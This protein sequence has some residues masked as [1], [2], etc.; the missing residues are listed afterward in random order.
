M[1][2]YQYGGVWADLDTVCFQPVEEWAPQG[3]HFTAG[4]DADGEVLRQ[5]TFAAVPGHG[6][7]G[8]VLELVLRNMIAGKYECAPPAGAGP[9]PA[10]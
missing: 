6:A 4:F 2:I 8:R 10:G 3:C 1:L 9:S 5:S 7:V